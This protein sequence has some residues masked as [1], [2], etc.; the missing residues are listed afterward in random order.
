LFEAKALRTSENFRQ[1]YGEA[2][3]FGKALS[4]PSAAK[5]AGS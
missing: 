2:R 3:A 1:A 5:A 4:W